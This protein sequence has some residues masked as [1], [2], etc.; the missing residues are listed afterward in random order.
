MSAT[1]GLVILQP[2]TVSLATEAP[3]ADKESAVRLA[4]LA[5]TTIN[6]SGLVAGAA[7][8]RSKLTFMSR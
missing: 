6:L 4:W 8:L 5:P 7:G 3:L 1:F 2:G